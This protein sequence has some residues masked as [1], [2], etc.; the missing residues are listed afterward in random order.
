MEKSRLDLVG[1]KEESQPQLRGHP[2][3][4]IVKNSYQAG[5]PRSV[6]RLQTLAYDPIAELVSNYRRLEA[7]LAYQEKLRTGEIVELT[8]T[9]KPRSYRAEVHHAL[10]DKL[11][12][13]GDKLLR[14]GY[15]R[16]PET[17]IVEE[18]KPMPL[19]VNLTKKGEVYT[20]NEDSDSEEENDID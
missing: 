17:T 13:I 9:G 12:A 15:G 7:E 11:I 10:Y 14:Y 18:K 2:D 16:V 5:K 1:F 4:R 3:S 19:V 20:V 8:A 6:R